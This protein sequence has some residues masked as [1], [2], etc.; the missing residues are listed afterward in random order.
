MHQLIGEE[1]EADELFWKQAALQESSTEDEEAFEV[2]DSFE[3]SS[4]DD[5]VS[6]S[7]EADDA[8]PSLTPL[9]GGVAAAVDEEAE[10]LLQRAER[11]ERLKKR[12]KRYRFGKYEDVALKDAV[13]EG[14]AR[15]QTS[16]TTTRGLLDASDRSSAS[17]PTSE[18]S[19]SR[20]SLRRSTRAASAEVSRILEE[21][22]AVRAQRRQ[23]RQRRAAEQGQRIV[24]L[25]QE[26]RL[27]EAL[28][29]TEPASRRELER[30]LELVDE[31]RTE[32]QKT[33]LGRRSWP[34][35]QGG[36]CW[37]YRG[38]RPIVASDQDQ[39][40]PKNTEATSDLSQVEWIA[41]RG[42]SWMPPFWRKPRRLAD[43]DSVD[44]DMQAERSTTIGKRC[45]VITGGP[46]R[47]RDPLTGQFYGNVEAFR[48]L[49]QR[50]K[51]EPGQE[52][53]SILGTASIA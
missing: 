28:E 13:V 53:S 51:N 41:F 47:Y 3:L 25:T 29:V 19:V 33:G 6:S 39:N 35:I 14:K 26:A 7:E 1:L 4:A 5:A 34:R 52:D 2:S 45:C 21:R 46:A 42:E 43:N 49:R 50:Y 31:K 8:N 37:W 40:E 32:S 17:R 36:I 18:W 11:R 38:Y 16:Q 24:A 23:E 9:G 15:V 12:R 44:G 27:Q 22:A 30:L 10:A 20:E 48:A